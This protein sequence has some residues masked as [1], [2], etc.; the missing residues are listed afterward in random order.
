M[1]QRKLNR[2][3]FEIE[4]V[5]IIVYINIFVEASIRFETCFSHNFFVTIKTCV[6][7]QFEF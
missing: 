5:N 1:S 3:T 4:V 6:F 2:K 7:K